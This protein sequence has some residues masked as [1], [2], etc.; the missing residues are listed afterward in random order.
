VVL[1][2]TLALIAAMSWGVGR[3][4]RRASRR[5]PFPDR[6]ADAPDVAEA[7]HGTLTGGQA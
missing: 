1:I 5:D 6:P 4:A 2:C 3:Y 7:P